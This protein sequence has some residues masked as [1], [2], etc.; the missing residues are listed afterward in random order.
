MRSQLPVKSDDI[1][2]LE[3]LLEAW[4][5]FIVGKRSRKDVQL[6]GLNLMDNL[7][8]LHHDLVRGSYQHGP[9][10]AFS[11]SDPKPRNIH[12]A[13]V[14]DRVLHHAFY[15]KL[16]PFF[17]RTFVTDSYS[18]RRDKGTHKAIKQFR[19]LAGRV[20]RNNTR[21]CWVLKCDIRKFFAS[22]DQGILLYILST[23]IPEEKV[24]WLLEK[25]VGSFHSTKLGKGL[26]L[27]NLTSQLLVN[28]YMHEFD[29]YMKHRLKARC[30]LRY[31]DDF[32]ILSSDKD[33]LK[34]FID[35]I[36]Q[37]LDQ[38]LQLELHPD[39][40]SIKTIASGVDWLG[41]VQFPH[42]LVLRTTTKRRMQRKL[43]NTPSPESLASY[44][45][46]IQHGNADSLRVESLDSYRLSMKGG[47]E[48][49]LMYS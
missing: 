8:A 17:D 21:T 22:I 39:K 2:S 3:N 12:K 5:E 18:C 33:E 38:C 13:S 48:D 46:L 16:Y 15:K 34:Q 45:G 9:Y 37:F 4:D 24:L 26:P 40:I 10:Q 30:Y 23:Y 43:Q 28:I 27:G 1:V 14:R 29:Q 32:A 7:M 49:R 42:H 11:I 19:Q 36:Q 41:W 6:F 31:A 20:S 47:Y 44:L 25:I 35:P